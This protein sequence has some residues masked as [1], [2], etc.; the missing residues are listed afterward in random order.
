MVAIQHLNNAPVVEGLID[1]RIRPSD[2]IELLS[3]ELLWNEFKGRYP[4]RKEFKRFHTSI[5]MKPENQLQQATVAEVAGYRFE[6]EDGKSII[7][8][9]LDGFSLSHLAP[10]KSWESLVAD[11]KEFWASYE[12]VIKPS[13][14]ARVATRFINR[15]DLPLKGALDFDDY[16]RVA[17]R[18]PEGLA[19]NLGEFL[20]R[21]VV[22]DTKTG[23]SIVVI[24]ALEA[25]NPKNNALPILI[26]IDVLKVVEIELS[27]EDH[28]KLLDEFR[29]LKNQAFFSSITAR[30]LELLK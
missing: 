1:L 11:A 20:T 15:I 16:L 2:G 14:I 19:Q 13:R 5:E 18:P 24:Q 29:L 10:Y 7:Q 12:K 17:P 28:W 30:T 3:L 23:A 4:V 27:S 22:N 6:S 9:Q 26:D 8:A 21:I 25:F